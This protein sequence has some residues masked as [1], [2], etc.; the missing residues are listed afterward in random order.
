MKISLKKKKLKSGKFSL[1]LEFYK[2]SSISGNGTRQHN[3]EFEYLKLY[4]YQTP[5][6]SQEKKENKEN[7]ELAEK[8]LAI[9]KADYIQ[10][11]HST[12]TYTSKLQFFSSNIRTY[13]YFCCL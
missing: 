9:R 3:R 8:I 13:H 12:A 5:N 1:Y 2:G 11:K 6:N 10:G 4:L 7:L